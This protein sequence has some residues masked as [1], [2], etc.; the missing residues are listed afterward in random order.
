MFETVCE[1]ALAHGFG[2]GGQQGRLLL[3][4]GAAFDHSVHP[5][6][7]EM[8]YLKAVFAVARG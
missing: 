8:R 7:P 6:V 2:D 5:A 1:D 3:A 4:S